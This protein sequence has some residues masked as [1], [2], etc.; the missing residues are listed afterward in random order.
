MSE[1]DTY[2]G[3]VPCWVE[4]LQDDPRSAVAFYQGLF[5]WE[6]AGPGPMPEGGEYYVARLRGRDVAGI[7]SAPS[8]LE[9]PAAWLTYVSVDDVSAATARAAAG[10][11]MV[12]QAPVDAPPAGSLA[13][14]LDPG[15]AEIGLWQPGDRAGAQLL[16]EPGAWAMSALHASDRDQ[17]IAFYGD[18]FGWQPEAFGDTVTC[19]RLPG[20]FGGEP[21]QPVP[22]DVVSV[23]LSL[24]DSAT[25]A[26]PHWSIDF[27]VADADGAASAAAT[28]G[29]RVLVE[30]H[31]EPP[32]RQAVLADPAGATFMIN[33]LLQP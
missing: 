1:R 25:S 22:R 21:T 24:D 20:Y 23:L 27:W 17:A 5:G 14:V 30:P 29:G 10:G 18:L 11:A 9:R 16:N 26:R 8:S 19:W 32:F 12:S 28:T 13:V 2:P 31:D 33:Q 7:G 3:G 4:T 15:G 6:F